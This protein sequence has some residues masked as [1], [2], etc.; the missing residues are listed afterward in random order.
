MTGFILVERCVDRRDLSH[1]KA[2]RVD[3]AELPSRARE[4]AAFSGNTAGARDRRADLARRLAEAKGDRMQLSQ[5]TIADQPMRFAVPRLPSKVLV[6]DE[7]AAFIHQRRRLRVGRRQ[8]LL[9]MTGS[10]AARPR[11]RARGAFPVA[12][13]TSTRSGFACPAAPLPI[14]RAFPSLWTMHGRTS[15]E[16]SS[17]WHAS[18]ARGTG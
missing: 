5:H 16:P 11:A 9:Q 4:A 14:D 8:R 17:G 6:D 3:P 10:R 2:K 18:L 13:T 1:E 15:P 7:L 12:C